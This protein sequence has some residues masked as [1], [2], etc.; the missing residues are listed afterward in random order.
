MTMELRHCC[1]QDNYTV[2]FRVLHPPGGWAQ[3]SHR[4]SS[5]SSLPNRLASVK[6]DSLRLVHNNKHFLSQIRIESKQILLKNMEEFSDD[7][8][9]YLDELRSLQKSVENLIEA[10]DRVNAK[11]LVKANYKS[12]LEQLDQGNGG[13]EHAAMLDTL[14]QL[15][16]MLHDGDAV[17]QM[18]K[19]MK[20]I[21]AN[22]G[23]HE[24]YL[25][26]FLEHVG[27]VYLLLGNKEEALYCYNRSVAVQESLSGE[28]S[29][30]LVGSLLA[31]AGVYTEPEERE[32]GKAI[33]NRIIHILEGSKGEACEELGAPLLHLGYI[34]LEENNP[35][36]AEV[37]IRRALNIAEQNKGKGGSIGVATCGLARIKY[38]KGD[39]DKA[40][41]LYH[42]G[43]DI[44]RKSGLWA[45]GDIALESVKME[46]AEF[47]SVVGRTKE[48]QDLW[49]E[50]L[51]EKERSIG[52]N[53][54]RLVVHLQNLATSYAQDGKFERCE[55]LLRRSLKLLTTS[56][57]PTA[58]Q[59]SIPLE[60]LATTLHHLGQNLEAESLARQCLNIREKNF[61]DD[62]LLIGEASNILASV[63]HANSRNDEALNLA[64]RALHIKEKHLGKNNKQ[65]A[66]VLDLLLDI[67]DDLGKTKEVKPVLDR[68]DALLGGSSMIAP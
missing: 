65:L 5:C 18:L 68:L 45:T 40:A 19:Q 8:G 10:G 12:L 44:L 56:L 35:E 63:L 24:P 32:K 13:L 61:P 42:S 25:D 15:N 11:A 55:P 54:P 51:H 9:E 57:G 3:L 43:L 52:V 4:K 59:V 17:H 66:F 28:N 58:P 1:C 2:G 20:N 50:V 46:A 62:H 16:L 22:I 7:L 23:V 36:E 53:S 47:F 41:E 34:S 29:P 14:I 60:F 38:A 64:W 27:N 26:A 48:A 37:H 6:F 39:H 49:E 67:M 33:Y 21:L 30:E 31:L